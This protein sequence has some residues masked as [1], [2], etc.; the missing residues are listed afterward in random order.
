MKFTSVITAL[1]C[2][3]AALGARLT[4]KRRQSREARQ[5]ARRASASG[6]L[7]SSQPKIPSDSVL[8]GIT[9]QTNVEYSS[10][11]AGAVLIGTGYTEVTGTVTVPTLTGSSASSTESAG[12][13]WVGIDGDTCDTAIL[14]TGIDWYVDGT[15]VSYDAWYE[16]YPDY[17]YT[18]SGISISAGD[19]IKMTVTATS[20]TGGSAVIEN[21]T[22]GTTVTEDFSN[23]SD[24]SLCEYNA[25]WI[26]EDFEE[27]SSSNDCSLV[28]FADFGT[29][30][31]TSASAVKSGTTVGV[32]GAT[33]IDIE[34]NN[35]VLTSCSDTSSTDPMAEHYCRSGPG[36][37]P[38]KENHFLCQHGPQVSDWARKGAVSLT[39]ASSEP[40]RTMDVAQA[41]RPQ[42]R[43]TTGVHGCKVNVNRMAYWPYWPSCSGMC[44]KLTFG[45]RSRTVL[46]TDVSGGAHDISFDTFQY[47]VYG[48]SATASPAILN[49]AQDGG[50][51]M[52]YEVVDMS[53]CLDI[54]TSDTG[55]LSFIAT[56]P[57]QVNKCLGE[58]NNW[59]AE[60]YEVR[61]IGDSQCQYGV[62]EVCSFDQVTGTAQCPSGTLTFRITGHR[63][64]VICNP[65][66]E[67][68]ACD[69]ADVHMSKML[70]HGY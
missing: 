19:S 53:Q 48:S 17:A 4:E 12:S 30:T 9:N 35:K 66:S 41:I 37:G 58:G 52:D 47:L 23:V 21:L 63:S 56:N 54:I 3:E 27:C 40:S 13:A 18:F 10:N 57:N 50:A 55:K 67:D 59:V 36:Q 7:R 6:A 45:S 70:A 65:T 1:L 42:S 32:T 49:P 16:W 25:E 22:T 20:K 14:Q 69:A 43:S 29:V 28:P 44:V 64:P 26:V 51:D 34:Q 11:W 39:E 31:F 62:D 60:N 33:I 24:G 2:A 46:H 38:S 5:L 8:E 68:Q 61:N 15:S